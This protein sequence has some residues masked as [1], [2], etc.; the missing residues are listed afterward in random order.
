[1]Q[2][3]KESLVSSLTS[4]FL[5]L[6]DGGEVWDRGK[7]GD[8]GEV[9]DRGKLGDGGEAWDRGKL[10]DGGEVWDWCSSIPRSPHL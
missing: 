5:K 1:M 10:G 9:W 3:W 4:S 6:G 7:L 8:G 2:K